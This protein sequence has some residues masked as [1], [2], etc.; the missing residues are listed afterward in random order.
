[1]STTPCAT[2]GA[3]VIVS[4]RLMSPT[5]VSQTGFPL[6]ASRAMVRLS[7]VLKNSFPASN[8]RPRFTTSQHATPC[9]A[10]AGFGLYDHFAGNPGL[11]RSS[12]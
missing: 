9:D 12:A 4:P 5:C 11:V 2:S 7:S 3:I 10:S 8:T 1:M 6:L